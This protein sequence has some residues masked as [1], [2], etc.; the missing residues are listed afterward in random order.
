MPEFPTPGA[1][2]DYWIGPATHDHLAANR[3][4]KRWFIK[5]AET[6][7]FI[8]Q[9]FAEI[10][11]ALAEG[12]AHE[13]A[14]AG[15][16]QRLAAIIVLDQFSRNIYRGAPQAFALDALALSLARDGLAINAQ[17][18]LTEVE[19]SFFFL[20]LEHAEDLSLQ[21]QCVACFESL[22]E[23]ARPSFRPLCA[24]SL[25]YAHQH[26]DIIR[27]FGRFPHRNAI[28]GRANTPEETAFLAQPGAGF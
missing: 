9:N 4:H 6:D 3:L 12:L 8:Q 23:T 13:W 22:V 7:A 14:N 19:Q 20:P 21:D 28:L 1:I 26:R 16:R 17:S 15:P 11:S 10:L 24:G 5:S 25:D 2:L 27:K 18:G